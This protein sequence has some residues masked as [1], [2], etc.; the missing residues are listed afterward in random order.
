MRKSLY[1]LLLLCVYISLFGCEDVPEIVNYPDEPI[2]EPII[3]WDDPLLIT[4]KAVIEDRLR[5]DRQWFCTPGIERTPN[6]RL[7]NTYI[8]GGEFEPQI[9]NYSVLLKSDDD[10]D[11]WQPLAIV[12]MGNDAR[13]F[14]PGL[15]ID[16]AGKLWFFFVVSAE[17]TLWTTKVYA[18]ICEFPDDPSPVFSP[19][20]VIAPGVMMNKP[21]VTSDG[22]WL[23]PI[24]V[25]DFFN[26]TVPGF[27]GKRSDYAFV[28][29]S[30]DQ[31][32]TFGIIG[33]ADAS[34]RSFDEHMILEKNDGSF[35]MYIRTLYGIAL[36]QSFDGGRIWTFGVDSGIPS[37]SSR[38]HIR[39]LR[40]GRVLMINHHNFIGRSHI[41]AL[42][43]DD[44][45]LTWPHTLLLDE[46]YGV[47]YPDAVETL[48]GFIYLTYEYLRYG[49]NRAILMA[50]INEEDII[51][52]EL[53]NG[54]SYLKKVIHKPF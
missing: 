15:W 28:Y 19:P 52:G 35:N 37:P 41:T 17:G 20:R 39:R 53:V 36:S 16:P 13:S 8:T 9:N 51:V 14:E 32:K 1:I 6:G 4:D 49:P 48:D 44:N 40:S 7:Y 31:G 23:F 5:N 30:R 3:I 27:E 42:L 11:T 29:E 45:G 38:F 50:K 21:I 22:R 54:G 47:M 2:D 18:A 34:D 33:Y 26:M 10:G 43:S 46:R 25:M 12:Y 24:Y